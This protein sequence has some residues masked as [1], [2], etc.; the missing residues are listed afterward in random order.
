MSEDE[1]LSEE[2]TVAQLFGAIGS[3]NHDAD[4]LSLDEA[5]DV[6]GELHPAMAG[7]MVIQL[8]RAIDTNDETV[9]GTASGSEHPKWHQGIHLA[10][11]TSEDPDRRRP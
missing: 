10:L 1:R 7:H 6:I 11:R 2:V 5:L 8:R 4:G 9:S 3:G